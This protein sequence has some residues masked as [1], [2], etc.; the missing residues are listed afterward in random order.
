[1]MSL[2]ENRMGAARSVKALCRT[3]GN[4]S[5]TLHSLSV[6]LHSVWVTYIIPSSHSQNYPSFLPSPLSRLLFTGSQVFSSSRFC[7]PSVSPPRTQG[8]PSGSGWVLQSHR[9]STLFLL[10]C[11]VSLPDYPYWP[12]LRT[13][14]S[15][16]ACCYGNKR[17]VCVWKR[18]MPE[19]RGE[20]KGTA[21]SLRAFQGNAGYLQNWRA[22]TIVLD[23]RE[24]SI[25]HT[26]TNRCRVGNV[27]D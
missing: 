26:N 14:L 22:E 2:H 4:F 1:M 15:R 19:G 6:D 27:P 10:S 3:V 21:G 18:K 16:F 13:D 25:R 12:Q 23:R 5:S 20:G 11:K 8:S 7:S 9:E 24:N 17:N